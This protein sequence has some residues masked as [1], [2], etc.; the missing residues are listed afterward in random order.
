MSSGFAYDTKFGQIETGQQV[1]TGDESAPPLGQLKS[2]QR[3]GD[4]RYYWQDPKLAAS[5]APRDD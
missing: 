5:T 3:M 2:R 4:R 1:R